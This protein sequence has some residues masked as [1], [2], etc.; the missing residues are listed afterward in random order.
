MK[1]VLLI[2]PPY[3]GKSYLMSRAPFPTG[4]L[5][6][7]AYLES[8]GVESRVK[9]FSYPPMK[10]KTTRPNQLKTGQSTY[11]RWGYDD[12]LIERWL[13]RNLPKYNQFVGVSSLMSSNWTGAYHVIDLIKKVDPTR[14]V[15][16]GGPHATT[17]PQHIFEHSKADYIC[18]GEG[19]DAL[20]N[21]IYGFPHE[22]IVDRSSKLNEQRTTFFPDMNQLPFPSRKLLLDE[23]DVKQMYVTFSRACP[24]NCSFCSSHLIHGRKWRTKTP[25]R[26][27]KEI[28]HYV[29]EWKVKN[30]II[31]DDNP[32]PGKRGIKHFK[33]VLNLF[34]DEPELKKI[35]IKASQGIPVYATADPELSELMYK[36]GF[37]RMRFPV[38][39]TDPG[40]LEDMNKTNVLKHWKKAVSNWKKLEKNNF[41][42]IILGYPF[43]ETIETMLQTMID[44]HNEGC[45]VWAS[46]FRLNKGTSLFDRCLEAGY[47][48]ENYD[49]INTQAFFIE[50]ENFN[51]KELQELMQITIAMNWTLENG[52]NILK[53]TIDNE[54]FHNFNPNP[55][56]GETVAEGRF[57]FTR[58]QNIVA[59]ILLLRTGNFGNNRPI[60]AFE[61]GGERLIYRGFRPSRV[62]DK[63]L[64][65]MTGIKTKGIKDYT[66]GRK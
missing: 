32:C 59:S 1:P 54:N 51:K 43:A 48:N 39:S 33:K 44:V 18:I 2:Y 56:I 7:A 45:I 42:L 46:H 6:I 23:R 10:S 29:N 12:L 36:V 3:E 17:F 53:D 9:D 22:A 27:I 30:I 34:L 49:P 50:T 13:R 57:K 24:H 60:V 28:K 52:F 63:L 37:R 55:A 31:E 8:K 35:R 4:P 58:S 21:F 40:V 20:Y 15:I 26:C 19:E 16:M 41:V 11:T 61:K 66:R 64:T 62:Y 38:E 47:T 14:I 25:E 5:Y 65:L